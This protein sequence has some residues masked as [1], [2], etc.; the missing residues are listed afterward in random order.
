MNGENSTTPP[1]GQPGW[2]F[3]PDD[4][5][6]SSQQAAQQPT[7]FNAATPPQPIMAPPTTNESQPVDP[8]ANMPADIQPAPTQFID[9]VETRPEISW[10]ASEFIA[11]EKGGMWYVA[12]G[13]ATIIIVGAIF[14]IT[15]DFF[16]IAAVALA[17]VAFGVMAKRKPKTVAYHIGPEGLQAN[18]HVY[19]YSNFK[20]FGL[21]DEGTFSS[22]V[23][24]PMKRFMLPVYV[25]FPPEQRDEIMEVLSHYIPFS[26]VE[27]GA[28]DRATHRLRF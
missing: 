7:A 27:Q 4:S 1:A 22:L 20:S 16:S 2:Q 10:S 23:F 25:Y 12:L 13:L 26:P 15:H 28:I 14:L 6:S 5:R 8:D 18:G 9:D 11:H 19:A 21:Q 3:K 17:M 24:M